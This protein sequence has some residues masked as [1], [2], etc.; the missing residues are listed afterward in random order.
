MKYITK[1]ENLFIRIAIGFAIG[2][3]LGFALPSFS[4][5]IKFLG[6][7]YLNLIKL[8]IIPILVCAVA[9]GIINS[10]DAA[11]L[12]KVGI[13]TVALYVVMFLAS[14]AVSFAVAMVI[15]PGLGV[16]FE[17]RPVYEGETQAPMN[18][19]DVLTSVIQDNMLKA[20]MDNAILPTIIFTL[21]ISLAILAAGDKGK[22]VR[23]CIN[24]LSAVAFSV[25]SL[26]METSPVG[27]MALM[28]YSIAEYGAGMF[29]AIGKY[30]LCCWLACIAVFIFVFVIPVK[31]YTR[32]DLKTYLSAC[33]KVAL[34]TLSTTSSAATLPTTIRVSTEDLG[35]PESIST[36]TL[37]LGCTINMCGG[38]CSFCCL[39]IFVAD[40]YSMDLPLSR[41]AA[42]A[43]AATLINMAA[44]GIPGGGIVLM[45]S[46]LTI[47]GLPVDLIGPVAAFYRLLDMAFTTINVEGDIAANLIISRSEGLWE[48]R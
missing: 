26:I 28:A 46:Y 39:S 33:G 32:V 8:M 22:V 23:D 1:K 43:I 2:I 13:K 48:P 7:I 27:V 24:S 20:M 19:G 29:T 37:P 36:F 4:H 42:M 15:R 30:I 31:A 17:N 3:I 14:F 10:S 9:G 16:V 6:D 35:A 5:G 44:P 12:K 18:F 45:T 47:F 11:A 21:I 40:F 41:L 38:A 25:L 34:M